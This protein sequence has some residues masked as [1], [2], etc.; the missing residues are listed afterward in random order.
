MSTAEVHADTAARPALALVPPVDDAL[1]I[2]TPDVLS[3]RDI[4]A[5]TDPDVAE[6]LVRCAA[7]AGLS[8]STLLRALLAVQVPRP[9]LGDLVRTT[10]RG[11]SVFQIQR[12]SADGRLYLGSAHGLHRSG[13]I[14]SA[15][16]TPIEE[17]R[18]VER[19]D[20]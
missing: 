10:R 18:S 9:C 19:S 16:W 15:E 12:I 8:V 11:D 4:L 17:I 7:G 13:C 1:P 5:A 20:R 6:Q 14:T 2:P 3:N